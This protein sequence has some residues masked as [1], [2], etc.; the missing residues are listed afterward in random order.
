VPSDISS[1]SI[2]FH[3]PRT[4][5]EH[6][7]AVVVLC[8]QRCTAEL[9]RS[10]PQIEEPGPVRQAGPHE[11]AEDVDVLDQVEHRN[12]RQRIDPWIAQIDRSQKDREKMRS[13]Y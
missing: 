13:L 2:S 4:M 7:Q 12:D 6:F 11:L 9:C 5:G 1:S 10:H 3:K 8:G